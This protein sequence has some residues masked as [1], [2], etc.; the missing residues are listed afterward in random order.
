MH[1]VCLTGLQRAFPEIGS[2]IREATTHLLGAGPTSSTATFEVFGV[3]PQNESWAAIETLLPLQ[4]VVRRLCSSQ[5]TLRLRYP[6]YLHSSATSRSV[7]HRSSNSCARGR[8]HRSSS[9]PT[10]ATSTAGAARAAA[11]PTSSRSSATSRRA[12]E[13]WSSGRPNWAAPLTPC[14]G[15]GWSPISLDTKAHT[16]YAVVPSAY[17]LVAVGIVDTCPPLVL[18]SCCLVLCVPKCASPS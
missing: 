18:Y 9:E 7:H 11:R 13:C 10:T 12:K 3:K 16:S 17:V 1:A 5:P 2:N 4:R 8:W 6:R 15:C 14:C